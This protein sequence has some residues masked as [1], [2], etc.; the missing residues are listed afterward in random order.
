MTDKKQSESPPAAKV[1]RTPRSKGRPEGSADEKVAAAEAEEEL[2]EALEQ[3]F[4]ASDPIAIESTLVPGG[5]R[6]AR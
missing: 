6:G 1:V 2:D 3:T 4:P 5:R